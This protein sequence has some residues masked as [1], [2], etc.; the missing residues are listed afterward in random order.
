MIKT[1]DKKKGFTLAELLVVVAIIAV[2][3]AVSIPIFTSQLDKARA[4]TD[5]ANVRSA[6]GAATTDYLTNGYEDTTVTYYYDATNGKVT[7]DL[8]AAKAFDVYGKSTKDIDLDKATGIPKDQIVSITI[9]DSGTT[10]A[11]ALGK[12]TGGDNTGD[13]GDSDTLA[14]LNKL[15]HT[16]SSIKSKYPGNGATMD[17]GTL[18]SDN[19]KLYLVYGNSN[20][21]AKSDSTSMADVMSEYSTSVKEVS[22]STAVIAKSEWKNNVDKTIKAGTIACFDGVYY[23]LEEDVTYNEYELGSG[24]NRNPTNDDRWSKIH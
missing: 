11:W 15:A 9:S 17:S 6:K 1:N 2:L 8:A 7:T 10:A 20:W 19:G 14:A 22:N 16:W 5:A 4:S 12:S 23:S 24:Q 3:V 18:V 13:T 21:Y